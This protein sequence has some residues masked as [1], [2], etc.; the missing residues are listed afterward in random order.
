MD[1]LSVLVAA[2]IPP[3][4]LEIKSFKIIWRLLGKELLEIPIRERYLVLRVIHASGDPSLL[5]EI[6][7]SK[8][9]VEK[10]V[11]AIGRRVKVVVDVSMTYCG[12]RTRV[13]DLGVKTY[14]VSLMSK[15]IDHASFKMLAGLSELLKHEDDVMEDSLIVVGNSPLF[16][17]ELNKLVEKGLAKPCAV[18]ACPPGFVNAAEAKSRLRRLDIPYFTVGG[19]RGGSPLASAAFNALVDLATNRAESILREVM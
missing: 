7:Y 9:F 15:D 8:D 4:S 3:S 5:K 6:S 12:I 10:G 13:R 19:T 11:D 2:L 17:M 18:I 14:V 16:L 1:V